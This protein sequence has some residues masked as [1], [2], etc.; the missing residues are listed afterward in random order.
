MY[1]QDSTLD[2]RHRPLQVFLRILEANH[3]VRMLLIHEEFQ[4]NGQVMCVYYFSSFHFFRRDFALN[5]R[6][7]CSST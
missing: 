5:N 6:S 3:K 4:A 1:L 7:A 2:I